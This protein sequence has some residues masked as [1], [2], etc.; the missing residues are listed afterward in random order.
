MTAAPRSSKI[1]KSTAKA[2]KPTAKKTAA[3]PTT[4]AAPAKGAARAAK[5]AAPE[6]LTLRWN[7]HE[8]PSSQHKAGLAGLALWVR[9]LPKLG[10]LKGTCAVSELSDNSF[11]LRVD[12]E[13]MQHLFDK[14]YAADLEQVERDKK[15]QKKL[16]DGSK[17]DV[18]PLKEITREVTDKKGKTQEKTFYVYE[19]TIPRGHLISDWD[20][21]AGKLWLKLWRD[22]VWSTLRG[23][24]ATREPYDARAE[25]R[26]IEDGL[27]A[28][29]E[30]ARNAD[31][32]AELPSTYYLGAQAKSAENVV[33]RDRVKN[34]FLLHFWPFTV[35]T[36]VPAVV[37]REGKREFTGFVLAVPDIVR[38]EEFVERWD[39]FARR[40]GDEVAGYRPR[41][42]VVDVA[43]ESALDLSSRMYT[44]IEQGK[45]ATAPWIGSV[46]TYHLEKEGNNIRIR[47][48]GR[49]ELRRSY[50]DE[51][52]HARERY[53]SPLF[54]RQVI[55]NILKQA[56]WWHGFGGLC[57]TSP[58]EL[59]I[60]DKK[61]FLHDCRE[62]FKEERPMSETEPDNPRNLE[63]II[64]SI[65]RTY[66]F[67]KL[68][69]KYDLDWS[70]SSKSEAGKSAYND[71]K[72][73]VA[74][75]AFLAVRSRTGADFVS[76]FT[77]TLCSVRQR[78]GQ[79]GYQ[80]VAQ[81]LRD[82]QRLEEIRSL[83]LLALA[84]A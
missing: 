8:L 63:E 22:M 29:D 60:E 76:Y 19:Q 62:A 69:S 2:A 64:F 57:A 48:V 43:V 31:Q 65:A 66:V 15:F 68:K 59:T 21:S 46:D 41:E 24:P 49:V 42:A 20:E 18:K 38:L 33:F 12:R 9:N 55:L 25:E 16:A 13:G 30:L 17:V 5:P 61:T 34:R 10:K 75:E 84:A 78:I 32:G 23:V 35:A 11:E 52:R 67:G 58:K 14:V 37:D 45:V 39:D 82:E 74:R 27:E 81:A 54:R 56:P 47:S 70:S 72:D 4:K 40:R 28:W 53:W 73:K 44:L 7:L 77:G 80:L 6:V 83:T 51:Y 1:S 71:K 36:Y 26:E 79:E 50:V 3:K